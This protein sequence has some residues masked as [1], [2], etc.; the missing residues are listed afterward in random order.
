MPRQK[1][2]AFASCH[3]KPTL[4]NT[5]VHFDIL[6]LKASGVQESK[7]SMLSIEPVAYRVLFMSMHSPIDIYT[8]FRLEPMQ[9]F[10]LGLSKFL[11][12]CSIPLLREEM[13]VPSAISTKKGE[14][15]ALCQIRRTI[16]IAIICFLER[17]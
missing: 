15:K 7:K 12:K 9:F 2:F 16:M 1:F 11:K 10:S 13:R 5:I 14:P 3:T 17:L 6:E 4:K 8:I